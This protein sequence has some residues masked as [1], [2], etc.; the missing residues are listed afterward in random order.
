MK[1]KF[2]K[3]HGKH[4]A[5]DVVETTEHTGKYWVLCNVAEAYDGEEKPKEKKAKK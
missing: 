4:V 1:V 3:D 2:L 5:G